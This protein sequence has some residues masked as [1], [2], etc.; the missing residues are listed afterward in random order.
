MDNTSVLLAL[1]ILTQVGITLEQIAVLRRKGDS[2]TEEDIQQ[3]IDEDRNKILEN[4]TN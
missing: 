4:A 2:L 3:I 1:R